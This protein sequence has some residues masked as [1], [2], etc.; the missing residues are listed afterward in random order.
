MDPNLRMIFVYSRQLHRHETIEA[1]AAEVAA[2]IRRL[3]LE[4]ATTT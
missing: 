2:T 3:A 1:K 4:P